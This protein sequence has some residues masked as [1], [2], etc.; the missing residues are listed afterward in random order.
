MQQNVYNDTS[1]MDRKRKGVE[2]AAAAFK[3]AVLGNGSRN[4]GHPQVCLLP[5]VGAV[6][7]FKRFDGTPSFGKVLRVEAETDVLIMVLKDAGKEFAEG[8]AF[9]PDATQ[10]MRKCIATEIVWP[11]DY[12]S[13]GADYVVRTSLNAVNEKLGARAIGQCI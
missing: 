12:E 1:S 5:P 10:V 2:F 9:T 6:I 4:D 3:K 8:P 13:V 7:G 11:L